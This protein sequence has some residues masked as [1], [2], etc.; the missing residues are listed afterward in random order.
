MSNGLEWQSC[1]T[2][3]HTAAIQNIVTTRNTG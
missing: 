2:H 3:I 1:S